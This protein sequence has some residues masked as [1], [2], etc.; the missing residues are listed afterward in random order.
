MNALASS[1][2]LPKNLSDSDDTRYLMAAL[3]SN[4]P[5]QDIGHSGTAMRFLAAYF[6]V[7]EG[8]VLLTGSERMKQRP[9]G[10]LV[11]ALR[12]LGAVIRYT[13]QEGC[14]PL[15]ISGG[16]KKGGRIRVDGGISSQFIS[17]LMMIGPVLEGGLH[18]I[19]EGEVVSPT[20]IRMTQALMERGGIMISFDGREIRVSQGSYHFGPSVVEADWSGASYWYQVAA[21]VPGS[22]IL[23]PNLGKDSLQG[24]S[25]LAALFRPLGVESRFTDEGVVL[26]SGGRVSQDPFRQDLT[27]SPDLVQTFAATLCALG[28][29]FTITGTRTLKVKESDRI[30]ALVAELGKLGFRIE[31]GDRGDRISW[32]GK[33]G[34]PIPEPVI[35]TYN[36]HRMA[37]AFAP[38]AIPFG[39]LGIHDPAVVTKSYP[40]YWSDLEKAG[41]RLIR[42]TG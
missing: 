27:G 37:M 26:R 38:L 18:I 16:L 30:A 32:E 25:V 15:E 1:G 19:L 34:E 28:I 13:E 23:L 6:C 11:K 10:P 2:Q 33:R 21:L 20:Y 39:P 40:A 14:P 17:A 4:A 12:E 29:P 41:F 42:D 5:T 31:S 24:D 35:D 3:G 9:V 8:R 22:D 7:R 36:D